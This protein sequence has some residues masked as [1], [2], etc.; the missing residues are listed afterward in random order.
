MHFNHKTF[1][2]HDDVLVEHLTPFDIASKI[3]SALNWRT[4]HATTQ[5]VST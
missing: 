3:T 2:L 1:D 4:G 5:D